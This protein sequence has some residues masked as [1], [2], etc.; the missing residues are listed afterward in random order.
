[1]NTGTGNNSS[2]QVFK[3]QVLH[4]VVILMEDGLTTATETWNGTSWTT[5][6][7]NT[8]SKLVLKQVLEHKLLL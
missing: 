8:Y 6:P 2:Q 3:Q 7:L 5:S 4:L 1:M